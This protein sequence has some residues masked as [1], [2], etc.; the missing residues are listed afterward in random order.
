MNKERRK[1]ITEAQ[2][3]LSQARSI[4]ET[5][6]DEEQEAYENLPESLQEGERGQRMEEAADI[7]DIAVDDL[8][9][10]ESKLEECKE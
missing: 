7:L 8:E 4:L 1:R 2:E 3:L 6:R 5:V 10:M 9:D